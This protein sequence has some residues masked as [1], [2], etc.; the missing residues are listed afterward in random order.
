[1]IKNTEIL[2]EEKKNGKKKWGE[3]NKEQDETPD[4]VI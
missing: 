2:E 3:K 1:M 4:T